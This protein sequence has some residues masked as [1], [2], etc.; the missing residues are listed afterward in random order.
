M[1]VVLALPAPMPNNVLVLLYALVF[2]LFPDTVTVPLTVR[3]PVAVIVPVEFIVVAVMEP[4]E[5]TTK[6]PLAT[7]MVPVVVRLMFVARSLPVIEPSEIVELLTEF[8]PGDAEMPVSPE[9]SPVKLPEKPSAVT[10][11]FTWRA[12]EGVF[13]PMPT[14]PSFRAYT[15]SLELPVRMMRDASLLDVDDPTIMNLADGVVVPMPTLP[16]PRKRAVVVPLAL[17]T[18]NPLFAVLSFRVAVMS[19]AY[20]V[21][22]MTGK[23]IHKINR[24]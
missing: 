3:F 16:S 4:E 22:P 15:T 11:P 24:K 13:V 10:V 9:P 5:S 14:L 17:T 12:V 7:D 6:F 2:T 20:R 8:A 18:E 1:P 19:A 23:S 21:L